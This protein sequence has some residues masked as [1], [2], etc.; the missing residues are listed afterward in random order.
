MQKLHRLLPALLAIAL[1]PGVTPAWAQGTTSRVTGVISDSIGRS[2]SRRH[3]H[4]HER[5]DGRRLHHGV[6]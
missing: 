6:E 1:F 2:H 4:A 3:H 5:G